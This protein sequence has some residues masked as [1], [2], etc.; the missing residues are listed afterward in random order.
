MSADR[1]PISSELSPLLDQFT[2]FNALDERIARLLLEDFIAL[3]LGNLNDHIDRSTRLGGAVEGAAT[4]AATASAVDLDDVDWTGPLH[5]GAVVWSA[6]IA[7]AASAQ[8]SGNRLLQAGILGYRVARSSAA[9]LGP[10]HARR[11]HVTATAGALGAAAGSSI[12]LGHNRELVERALGLVVL[13]LGGLGQAALERSG[14]ARATRA[15]AAAEGVLAA[16]MATSNLPT[17]RHPWSGIRGV[18]QVLFG[19]KLHQSNFEDL[20]S[21]LSLRCYPVNG[22]IHS[23]VQAT[24][25]LN[26]AQLGEVCEI[27]WELPSQVLGLVD[28]TDYG[29]WWNAPLAAARAFGTGSPWLVNV[30]GPWDHLAEIVRLRPVDLPVG[31]ARVYVDSGSGVQSREAPRVTVSSDQTYVAMVHQK[32]SKLL[33]VDPRKVIQTVDRMLGRAPDW[34]EISRDL[35]L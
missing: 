28:S 16:A 31:S 29:D 8:V 9:H 6:V 1:S 21:S 4:L 17:A 24:A 32:W 22:F 34:S 23:A 19:G 12:V 20:G 25:A 5:P 7:T 18:E 26:S 35:L 27:V 33:Q 10:E 30:P 14:A 15:F 2:S 13:N 3:V 11:W